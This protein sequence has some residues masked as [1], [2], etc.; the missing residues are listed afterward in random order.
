VAGA[1]ARCTAYARPMGTWDEGLLDNDTACDALGDLCH[2]IVGD[3]VRFGETPTAT[4][5]LCAA[6][7]VLLQLS[8]YDFGLDS[9]R[10]PKIVA[11]AKLHEQQLARAAAE[12]RR[13]MALVS[14][15]RGKELAEQPDLASAAHAGIFNTGATTSRFGERHPAL[16]ATPAGAAYVQAIVDRCVETIEGELEDEENLSDMCREVGSLGLLGVLM[17]LSPCRVPLATVESWRAKARQGVNEL[18]ERAD[19]ELEFH[20]AYYA[21][22][23][24]A[25]AVLAERFATGEHR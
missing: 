16:F 4:D 6:I 18:R 23:D 14:D 7:G 5:E 10:G 11:A 25:F 20:E 13:V 19:E 24:R 17:V 3:I 21:N 9:D 1:P 8:D 22:L 2:E 15:G 12:V